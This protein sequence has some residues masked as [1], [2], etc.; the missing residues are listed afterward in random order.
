MNK[1]S[2]FILYII[3]LCSVLFLASCGGGGGGSDSDDVMTILNGTWRGN[4]EDPTMTM[5]NATLTISGDTI[6]SVLVDGVDQ[7]LTGSI[8]QESANVFTV[9]LSDATKA[10][11]IVDDARQHLTFVD[12]DFTVGVLQKNAGALPPFVQEDIAGIGSGIVV[13]TDFVTFQEFSGSVECVVPGDC[14]GTDGYVGDFTAT[15]TYT[16]LGRWTGTSNYAGG[17]STVS[18]FLSA[19][20][21][22]AGSWG[23]NFA[24]GVFP[25]AC[26]FTAWSF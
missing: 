24:I 12:E 14:T 19:D 3:L 18:V 22:F 5:H 4:L 25:D 17:S 20:K 21:Q 1:Q 13:T 9:R 7:G 11:F 8:V 23:C 15:L 26:S 16:D 6:T 2:P 10:G